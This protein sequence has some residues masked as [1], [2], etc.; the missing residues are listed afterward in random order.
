MGPQLRQTPVSRA[1]LTIS[2]RIPSKG[3]LH[4]D[5]P[6]KAHRERDA[7]FPEPSIY[8]SKSPW[9]E[10]PPRSPVGPLWR[11]MPIS[12]AFFCTYPDVKK[13]HLSKSSVKDPPPCSP[14]G[15]PVERDAPSLEPM[16]HSVIIPQSPQLR[17]SPM[18][19]GENIRLPST[20][21]HVGGRPCTQWDV[22]WFPMGIVY[23]IAVTTPVP[24]SLQ[25]DT[26][27]IALGRPELH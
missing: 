3:A 7:V 11:E 19:W 13:S 20:E 10:P 8:L 5:S 9:N 12:I 2:F 4:T 26:F 6:H 1:L 25:H 22:A 27:H 16:V 24:C 15:A 17:T 18:K 14:S 21:P 23:D